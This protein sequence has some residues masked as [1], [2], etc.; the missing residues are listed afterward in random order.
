[1]SKTKKTKKD[2]VNTVDEKAVIS[3]TEGMLEI[4]Q[5]N[6]ITNTC[7]VGFLKI[8]FYSNPEEERKLLKSKSESVSLFDGHLMVHKHKVDLHK[9]I[10][11]KY[12]KNYAPYMLANVC[13]S[14]NIARKYVSQLHSFIVKISIPKNLSALTEEECSSFIEIMKKSF[15]INKFEPVFRDH[16]HLW[17][18]AVYTAK[19]VADRNKEKKKDLSPFEKFKVAFSKVQ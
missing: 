18:D 13:P 9:D 1:M 2:A 10:L 7:L 6:F 19:K 8:L 5:G 16:Y 17:C 12:A 4:N 3:S 14:L 15:E 11:L